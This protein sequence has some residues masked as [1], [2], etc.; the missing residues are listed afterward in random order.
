ML[1]DSFVRSTANILGATDWLIV[2]SYSLWETT[3]LSKLQLGL[4]PLKV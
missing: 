2:F 1:E 3:E 4:G